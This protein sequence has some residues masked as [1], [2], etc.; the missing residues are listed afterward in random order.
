MPPVT[1]QAMAFTQ[2]YNHYEGR[3]ILIDTNTR[4]SGKLG[5]IVQ[6][7]MSVM[8]TIFYAMFC[9]YEKVYFTGS[10][11]L[12][13][14]VRDVLLVLI[15]S[16]LRPNVKIV[17]H[18]HGATLVPFLQSMPNILRKIF[19]LAYRKISINIVLLPSMGREIEE[20][21]KR[22]KTKVVSN[23]YDPILD[24]ELERLSKLHVKSQEV[25]LGYFSNLMFSKGIID[26]LDSFSKLSTIYPSISL[27]LA[28]DFVGD[29][30]KSKNQIK[31]LTMPYFENPRIHYKGL[32]TNTAKLDFLVDI[33]I[34]VLPT[35]H[36]GEAFPISII[37]A[38]RCGAV[39][40]TT[41]HNYLPEIV[42]KDVGLLFEPHDINDL[43]TKIQYFLDNPEIRRMAG[44][45]NVEKSKLYYSPQQYVLGVFD[46]IF[47]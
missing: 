6:Y 32:L 40:I 38:M 24:V 18:L 26:L 46:T 17:N 20:Y 42:S 11:T 21:E 10:R 13:G 12:A 30:L 1:G 41:N 44:I 36:K 2:V 31:A 33:D 19:L 7:A 28:G 47:E 16:S 29:Y 35:F 39:I 34:F 9:R 45:R 22:I 4:N 43:S 8:K 25:R 3:K 14:G 37:E 23:S 15:V 5:K 27:Y